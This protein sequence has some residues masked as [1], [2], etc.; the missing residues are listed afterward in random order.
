M[1]KFDEGNKKLPRYLSCSE[2]VDKF[3]MDRISSSM[4]LNRKPNLFFSYS[5][6]SQRIRDKY[7]SKVWTLL[8]YGKTLPFNPIKASLAFSGIGLLRKA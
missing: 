2:M 3:P 1:N 8:L 6:I 4:K 7:T 5:E